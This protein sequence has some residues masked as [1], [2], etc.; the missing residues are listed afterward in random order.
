MPAIS[1]T[2]VMTTTSQRVLGCAVAA[3][4]ARLILTFTEESA[5]EKAAC[6][7]QSQ[8]HHKRS[9]SWPQREGFA[10]RLAQRI[11]PWWACWLRGHKR[12]IPPWGG[13]SMVRST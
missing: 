9:F 11:C 4:A 3:K 7:N 12:F 10:H 2:R 6:K 13:L 8:G 5:D 1:W